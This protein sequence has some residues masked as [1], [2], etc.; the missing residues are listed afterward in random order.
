MADTTNP[1]LPKLRKQ[2]ANLVIKDGW[3]S[4]KVARYSGYNHSTILR[5]VQKSKE[6]NLRTIPT[7]SSKPFHHPRELSQEVKDKII[8]YRYQYRRCAEVIHHFLIRDGYKVSLSSVE[9]TLKRNNLVY[10]SK[11]KKWHQYPERPI[12]E[13]PGILIQIDTIFEELSS[14]RLYIYTLIDLFSR[15]A[16]ALPELNISTHRSLFFVKQAQIIA[17]FKFSTLQ[18]DYGSEFSKW[19]TKRIIENGF[20]HRHSRVR[21]PSDNGHLE[22]F[23][24]TIQDECLSHVPRNLKSYQKEISNYLHYYNY[25]RPHMALAMKTPMEMLNL[26]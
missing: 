6:S 15:W 4:Y 23:N 25:E 14:N 16:Y 20:S 10:H 18:L 7:L 1:K 22:R 9:R 21:T 8:E 24:R 3:N 2:L 13:K 11:W 17:P 19:F 12:P 5:W 26:K